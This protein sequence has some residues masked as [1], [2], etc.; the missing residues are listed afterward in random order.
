MTTFMLG[1]RVVS[2]F[3]GVVV[4]QVQRV[5]SSGRVDVRAAWDMRDGALTGSRSTGHLFP[6]M[7]VDTFKLFEPPETTP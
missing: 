5:R 3:N 4:Y 1:D 6:D 2:K 7:S